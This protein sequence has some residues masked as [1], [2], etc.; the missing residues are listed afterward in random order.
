MP[1]PIVQSQRVP[2]ETFVVWSRSSAPSDGPGYLRTRSVT[3]SLEQ[4][5]PGRQEFNASTKLEGRHRR[6]A[7]HQARKRRRKNRKTDNRF[8][9]LADLHESSSGFRE[10]AEAGET[11]TGGHA[12]KSLETIPGE[13][14]AVRWKVAGIPRQIGVDADD[15]RRLPRE[16][17]ADTDVG[18]VEFAPLRRRE[19][20]ACFEGLRRCGNGGQD[21]GHRDGKGTAGSYPRLIRERPERSDESRVGQ[22]LLRPLA[23]PR[24]PVRRQSPV[25]PRAAQRCHRL[26]TGMI[27]PIGISCCADHAWTCSS[28][29]KNRIVESREADVVPPLGRRH[30]EVHDAVRVDEAML[31]RRDSTIGASQSW[32]VVESTASTPTR[33]GNAERV[34]RAVGEPRSAAAFDHEAKVGTPRT[35]TPSTLPRVRIEHDRVRGV[36][37]LHRGADLGG[38]HAASCVDS[39]LRARDA[40]LGEGLVDR[41]SDARVRHVRPSGAASP[42]TCAPRDRSDP[43]AACARSGASGPRRAHAACALRTS[44]SAARCRASSAWRA[45]PAPIVLAASAS[46]HCRAS[47]SAGERFLAGSALS[48]GRSFSTLAMSFSILPLVC[49]GSRSVPLKPSGQRV[50]RLKSAALTRSASGASVWRGSSGPCTQRARAACTFA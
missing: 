40:A 4:G 23:R 43:A 18:A 10:R 1:A 11:R 42:R 22:Q 39:D 9:R 34:P 41:V 46:R 37:A 47:S 30:G 2:P 20:R 49:S 3:S 38:G 26:A 17:P 45:A 8:P 24:L 14:N 15:R 16:T 44:C 25:V 12:E 32:H 36:E 21:E 33:I 50:T 29:L 48:V 35:A 6:A 27:A 13:R 5:G 28:D 7:G 19:M 31:L